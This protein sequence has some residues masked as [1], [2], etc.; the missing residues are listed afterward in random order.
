M[1]SDPKTCQLLKYIHESI[2]DD[3]ARKWFGKDKSKVE[4]IDYFD[5]VAFLEESMQYNFERLE[6]MGADMV[7]VAKTLSPASAPAL[8]S[9]FHR[10]C[11]REI[12]NRDRPRWSDY[13]EFC[14]R[15]RLNHPV[16]SGEP[17]IVPM[18]GIA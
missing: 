16:F 15:R 11:D 4:S 12:L 10:L 13:V 2:I 17:G 1:P 14:S 5:F 9:G 8:V 3:S 6:K 7:R 18:G